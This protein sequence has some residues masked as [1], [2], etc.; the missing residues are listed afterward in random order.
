[1]DLYRY[2]ARKDELIDLMVDEVIAGAV[3]DELPHHWR[4]ALTAI[5]RALRAVCLAHPW[6]VTAAGQQALI[7]P[8]RHAP[9]RA[10]APGDRRARPRPGEKD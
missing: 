3:L 6:M 1:M 4:D 5:A 8:K 2:F 7:G 10:V 9:R